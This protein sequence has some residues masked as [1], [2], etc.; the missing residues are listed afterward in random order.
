MTTVGQPPNA[1]SAYCLLYGS[2]YISFVF[3]FR[4]VSMSLSP[5]VTL[6]LPLYFYHVRCIAFQV[7][8]SIAVCVVIEAYISITGLLNPAVVQWLSYSPTHSIGRLIEL[9][10]V[11]YLRL[12]LDMVPA[13]FKSLNHRHHIHTSTTRKA[14]RQ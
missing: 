12:E 3:P 11:L 14:V 8:L 1:D 9:V 7:L 13:A 6:F 10:V 4:L 2:L 5:D